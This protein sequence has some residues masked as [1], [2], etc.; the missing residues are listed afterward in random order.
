MYQIGI[1]ALVLTSLPSWSR[2]TI[3]TGTD[4]GPAAHVKAFDASA[5]TTQSFLPYGGFT[6]GVRVAAGDVNGD[7]LA[8]II[9]G[10]GPGASG[11]HVKVFDGRAGA[12]LLSFLSYDPLFTGGVFV[13][14]A[15][16]PVPEPGCLV[17]WTLGGLAI[18]F[19]ARRR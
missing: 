5:S 14:G 16:D 9:T 2:A 17:L 13:A 7:G 12:T 8:D 18:L 4:A 10:A 15:T 1:A 6:G 3:I 11:G 19:R